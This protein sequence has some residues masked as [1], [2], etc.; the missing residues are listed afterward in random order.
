MI[1]L[2]YLKNILFLN[3]GRCY[4]CL[5]EKADYKKHI[6]KTCNS[7]LDIY[8]KKSDKSFNYLDEVYFSLLYNRYMRDKIKEFKFQDKN[9]LYKAFSHYLYKTYME[10]DIGEIDYV[11]YVPSHR[12]KE[13][14]RGYNQSYLLAKGLSKKIHIDLISPVKKLSS[15]KDQSSLDGLDRK[16]N[17]KDIFYLEGNFS[18]KDKKILLIDD[19]I[20]TGATLEEVAKVL[21]R[22]GADRIIGLC[23]SSSRNI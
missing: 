1:F 2:D 21:K 5:G 12:S 8:N 18:L 17:L 10:N 7:K 19:I 23:L 3:E 14:K 9:Y 6:C 15:T 20:T 4:L 13:V 11:T 22:A 16:T